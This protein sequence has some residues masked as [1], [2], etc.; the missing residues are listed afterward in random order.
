MSQTATVHPLFQRPENL[1]APAGAV[2]AAARKM[3][4]AHLLC[5]AMRRHFFVPR[6]AHLYGR[7]GAKGRDTSFRCIMCTAI[8]YD[9]KDGRGIVTKRTYELPEGYRLGGIGGY[10]GPEAGD[11]FSREL[12]RRTAA[13]EFRLPITI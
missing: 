4:D 3:P 13:G 12:D 1:Y 5:H 6:T 2:R 9:E 8:R 10:L 7:N 11:I